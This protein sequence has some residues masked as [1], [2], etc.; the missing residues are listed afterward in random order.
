MC[1]CVCVCV[2]VCCANNEDDRNSRSLWLE[3][4]H[5]VS[6]IKSSIK[7]KNRNKSHLKA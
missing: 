6:T 7:Q 4:H 1:V 2:C 3:E 5:R